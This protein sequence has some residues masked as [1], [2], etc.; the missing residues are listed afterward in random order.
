MSFSPPTFNIRCNIWHFPHVPPAAHDL[1]SPCNLQL[2]RRNQ[3][4][5]LETFQNDMSLLLPA[6]TD[7]R[8]F[9]NYG[10]GTDIV[11]VP[12]GTGRFYTV[13]GVDDGGKGFP[14]EFR[15]GLIRATRTY[16]NWPIPIP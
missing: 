5:S 8:S 4:I 1:Q 15:F 10:N 2:G 14:N 3:P 6:G 12:A 11:E 13:I 16:G 7:L 9:N